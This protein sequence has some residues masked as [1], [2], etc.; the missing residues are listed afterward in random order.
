MTILNSIKN[1]WISDSFVWNDLEIH[2]IRMSEFHWESKRPEPKVPKTKGPAIWAWAKGVWGNGQGA[3]L[4]SP[5]LDFTPMC[6]EEQANPRSS[7]RSC[8]V[9][10]KKIVQILLTNE[11]DDLYTIQ[12]R[13]PKLPP[14]RPTQFL[15]QALPSL[16]YLKIQV[17]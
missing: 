17:G 8:P 10:P 7:V 3:K 4:V 6:F 13:N 2:M 15:Q 1:V 5:S 12:N 16:P 11:S 14:N 9:K